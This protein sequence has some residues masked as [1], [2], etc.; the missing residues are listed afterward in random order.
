MGSAGRRGRGGGG[1]G[2]KTFW[3]PEGAL[4]A[5]NSELRA[6]VPKKEKSLKRCQGQEEWLKAL[7]QEYFSSFKN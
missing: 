4:R 3:T 2:Q 6:L 1:V 7:L 5:S